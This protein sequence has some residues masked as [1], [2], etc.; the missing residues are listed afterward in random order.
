LSKP[1]LFPSFLLAFLLAR[2]ILMAQGEPSRW[3]SNPGAVPVSVADSITMTVLGGPWFE[4][5]GKP[6]A[7]FSPD[8]KK[9][10]VITHRG[11]IAN[12]TNEYSLLLFSVADSVR[13]PRSEVLLRV[14]SSSNGAAIDQVRWTQDSKTLLLL[15]RTPGKKLE[16]YSLDIKERK[17]RR[18][19]RHSTDIL[20]F[21]ATD[22]ADSIVFLA[23]PS[24][25]RFVDTTSLKN[26]LIIS[27]QQLTDLLAG[28]VSEKDDYGLL[29][30]L[31]LYVKREGVPAKHILLKDVF[32]DPGAISVSPDGKHAIVAA[33]L[34]HVPDSWKQYGDPIP[35]WIASHSIMQ[36]FL[37]DTVSGL[38]MPLIDAPVVSWGLHVAWAEDGRSVIVAGTDLPLDAGDKSE[39][40]LRKASAFVVEVAIATS[41]ITEIVRGNFKIGNWSPKS[42]L[43]LL[44]PQSDVEGHDDVVY[45][46][47][48][49]IWR[50]DAAVKN[51]VRRLDVVE[52]QGM[53]TPPRLFLLNHLSGER[54]LLLDLNPQLRN[55][56]LSKVQ[57]IAWTGTDGHESKGG[58]YLPGDYVAGRK[59][60]LI[61]QTHGWNPAKFWISGTS[62]A[63]FAA[64]ALAGKGFVVVQAGNLDSHDVGT[65]REGPRAMA[66]FEGLIDYLD[67]KG[68]VDRDRVGLV[69]W[70]RTAYHVRYTLAFSKY[71]FAAAVIADGL[72]A[73]YFQ[74]L[75]WLNLGQRYVDM[76]EDVNGGAPFGE[77]L[78][79]WID[80]VPTFNLTRVKTPV[81]LLVFIP[82]CVLD[83]WEWFAGSKHLGRPLEFVW[84]P[85]AQHNPEK[86]WERMVAQQGSVDWFCFWLKGE[87]DADPGKQ[88]QYSR[89]HQFRQEQA[90]WENQAN[91][92]AGSTSS[93]K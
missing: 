29:Y 15:A 65:T 21:D 24:P 84:L 76:F 68:L 89:W 34:E 81:R 79:T 63:G 30:P 3:V 33:I 60:P 28:H 14:R 61:I 1:D 36:Y 70:S 48:G 43:L 57:E 40:E 93:A 54:K 52:D 90:T 83:N 55:R 53:N 85:D 50:K 86:P 10:V 78:K 9:F 73:G 17:L 25:R 20:C 74:Y 59:Y 67:G 88:E 23:R 39:R 64:Q 35:S 26:G 2:G 18:L 87:E 5:L 12:N 42:R 13:L 27:T 41:K 75:S 11:N 72:D 8:Q 16:V 4:D 45:R 22:S 38:V 7:E 69:G 80:R 71:H 56:K 37:V 44:Q 62:E 47:I 82:Y 91:G 92:G 66:T 32:P 46:K 49:S 31:E 77:G 6:V 19:W 58:L 51:R